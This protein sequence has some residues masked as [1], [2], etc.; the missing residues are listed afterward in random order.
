MNHKLNSLGTLG[1]R[2]PGLMAALWFAYSCQLV[3]SAGFKPRVESDQRP[4]SHLF[5]KRK[6][7]AKICAASEFVSV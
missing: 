5:K 7:L 4:F 2:R 3:Q 6:N 1:K